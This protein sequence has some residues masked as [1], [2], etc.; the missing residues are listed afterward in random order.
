MNFVLSMGIQRLDDGSDR[1]D[2]QELLEDESLRGACERGIEP[3]NVTL[4]RSWSA[5]L[6]LLRKVPSVPFRDLRSSFHGM[7]TVQRDIS[8]HRNT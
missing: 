6:M 2:L 8:G 7:S 1:F 3:S 4:F 5:S